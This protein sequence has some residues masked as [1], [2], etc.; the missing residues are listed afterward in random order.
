MLRPLKYHEMFPPE[1]DSYHPTAVGHTMFLDS[2]DE[3]AAATVIKYI[4]ESDAVMRVT[5][6]RALGGAMSRVGQQDTAF[7]HRGRRVMANV[8]SFFTSPEDRVKRLG[9]V[10]D[11]AGALRQ[12]DEA[13]YVGFLM[14]YEDG[15]QRA[16]P[17]A[18]G[19]RLREVKR[20]YDPEN[21]FRANHNIR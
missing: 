9:W 16:Y 10:E 12:T 4:S 5:Q 11:F 13:G 19:E 7:A 6:L 14:D 18:T 3:A 15:V 20:R 2:V 1:D 8:A 21:L 17:G